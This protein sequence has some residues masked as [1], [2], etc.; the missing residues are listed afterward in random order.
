M[1]VHSLKQCADCISTQDTEG[2]CPIHVAILCKQ[3]R[4]ADV[5]LTQ[6]NLDLTTRDKH[7]QTPFAVAMATKDN[8][9]GLSI[10]NREPSAAEQVLGNSAD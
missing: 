10:L 8:Q 5:L 6:A 3:S 1:Y 7:N 2:R 9:I 4:C